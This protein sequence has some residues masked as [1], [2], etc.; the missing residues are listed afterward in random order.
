MEP[1]EQAEVAATALSPPRLWSLCSL[2][3]ETTTTKVPYLPYPNFP[4]PLRIPRT[5]SPAQRR[6]PVKFTVA[7]ATV[8]PM[9]PSFDPSPLVAF[10]ERLGV[11]YHYLKNPIVDRAASGQLQG[12]SL[13][14]FCSR[15][16]RGLL[17]GCCR[18]FGYNKLVLGQHLDDLAESLFMSTLHNGQVG[19]CGRA[20]A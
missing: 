10:L 19:R 16:K 2:L 20:T 9:T 15:M 7:A 17:Y 5:P 6:A 12:D 3:K 4:L 18:D 13:C 11:T 8:D 14:A 1:Q